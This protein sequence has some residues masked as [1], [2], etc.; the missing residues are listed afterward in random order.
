MEPILSE[1]GASYFRGKP[2]RAMHRDLF[3]WATIT[4]WGELKASTKQDIIKTFTINLLDE[5]MQYVQLL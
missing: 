4:R 5:I 1:I 3:P 2:N